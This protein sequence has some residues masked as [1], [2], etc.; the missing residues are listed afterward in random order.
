MTSGVRVGL[1]LPSFVDDAQTALD[2]ARV[3][4]SSG[5][6]GVF[7]YDH[8][9]RRAR[10]GTR[11][12][13]LEA[14]ALLG[15]VAGA[16]TR[17]LVGTLVLRASVRPPATSAQV[18]A[19][20]ARLAPGRCAMGIGAGDSESREEN[21]AF[22]LDFD[23]MEARV[24]RLERTVRAARDHG[25]PVWVGGLA[26]PVRE[27]AAREADGWNAWGLA[28]ERFAIRAS[29]VSAAA[30]RSPFECSWSGLVVLDVTDDA[31]Q[32][33]ANGLDASAGTLIGGPETV[34]G[35]FAALHDAGAT[36]VIVGAVDA[37]NPRTARLLGEEVKAALERG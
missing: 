21:D 16:T 18:V 31:A 7:V 20:A 25:A 27:I 9:F 22:G 12:P 10:D 14:T 8:L 32:E 17:V 34:A 37:V 2:V 6:D 4:E 28:P 1:T 13:A 15:A 35:A 29:E 11:R 23:E 30:S 3:A 36:W 19:T 33:R 24:A 26:E 5:V